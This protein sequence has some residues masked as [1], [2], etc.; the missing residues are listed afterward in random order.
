MVEFYVR[1]AELVISISASY[2]ETK[3]FCKDYLLEDV[4]SGIDIEV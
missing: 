1:M 2:E 4:P 3:Q